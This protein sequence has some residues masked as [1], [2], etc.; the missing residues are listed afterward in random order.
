MSDSVTIV[1]PSAAHTTAVFD[2]FHNTIGFPI[3][4]QV[5]HT[6]AS[7][8]INP[9]SGDSI[10]SFNPANRG[11]G[12]EVVYSGITVSGRVIAKPSDRQAWRTGGIVFEGDYMLRIKYTEE[13]LQMVYDAE[14]MVADGKQFER[15]A[16]YIRGIP[17]RNRILIDTVER[18]RED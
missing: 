14:Y 3:L 11:T 17:E 4:F 6:V 15:H 10:D 18:K 16:V 1:F 9:I 2:G 5:P 8:G 13:N 12:K 7:S